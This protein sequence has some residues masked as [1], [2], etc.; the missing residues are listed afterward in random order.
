MQLLIGYFCAH[1]FG[2]MKSKLPRVIV[3]MF[4]LVI[5]ACK[6]TI[7]EKENLSQVVATQ[8]LF[9]KTESFS[10][11]DVVPDSVLVKLNEWDE[12]FDLKNMFYENFSEISASQ[13]LGV[14]S[15]LLDAVEKAVDSML[16]AEL[17]TKGVFAR[18]YTLHS[19]A[20]RL[21]DMSTIPSIKREE[22][23]SQVGKIVSVFNSLNS[24]I[25]LVYDQQKFDATLDFDESLFEF[26]TKGEKP[27]YDPAKKRSPKRYMH[28]PT[29]K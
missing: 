11:T 23:L 13:A 12:Y 27:Y 29:Q 6:E 22:V 5:I 4:F 9:D 24:K 25:N 19:E 17:N 21:K 2:L 18:L 28:Q 3:L 7:Q 14:S 10:L 15:E 26:N 8:K 20:L 16:V 1:L